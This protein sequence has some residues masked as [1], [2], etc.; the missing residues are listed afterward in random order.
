MTKTIEKRLFMLL[1]VLFL[2]VL[3]TRGQGLSLGLKGGANLTDLNLSSDLLDAKYRCGWFFGPS[4]RISLPITLVGFDVSAFYEQRE[5]KLNGSVVRQKSIVVPANLRLN[6]GVTDLLGIY[7]A[8]GPQ[9]GF[10]VGDDHFD[11]FDSETITSTFQLKKAAFS[12]NLGGGVFLTKHLEVGFAYNIALG[13]TGEASF[14]QAVNDIT[15][16][17]TYSDESKA[18]TWNLSAAVYF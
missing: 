15:D 16:K 9:F 10:N 8:A 4:L 13:K 6:F 18:K 17:D 3:P 1:A 2:I 14:R 7:L 12:V 11:L 5:T